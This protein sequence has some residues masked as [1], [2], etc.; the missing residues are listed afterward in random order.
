MPLRSR[1]RVT[2]IHNISINTMSKRPIYISFASPKGGVGKTTL[3][4]F[5]ASYLH[6]H[7]GYNVAVVDCN[8][9]LYSI[10]NER[11]K[12]I[13]YMKCDD[14]GFK[15]FLEIRKQS[16]K[17]SYPIVNSSIKSVMKDLKELRMS[18]DYDIILFDLP[19]LMSVYGTSEL[20]TSMDI[21]IFPITDC[22]RAVDTTTRYIETLNEHII[23]TGKSTIKE[24]YLLRNRI[25]TAE[26][27][28]ALDDAMDRL[29]VL[30][31]AEVMESVIG[32]NRKHIP[33]NT[34]CLPKLNN[35]YKHLV[36]M[37]EELKTIII[38]QWRES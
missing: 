6:Y 35:H 8:Y 2:T 24:I 37:V 28:H 1:R 3:T 13:E 36:E 10:A 27:H 21:V 4:M 18:E 14:R 15:R 33:A 32:Y 22:E 25:N 38:N 11:V 16:Q 12:E 7:G 26:S 20:L 29:L 34:L 31:G 23:T 17:G 5:A 19:S 30:S 9:P